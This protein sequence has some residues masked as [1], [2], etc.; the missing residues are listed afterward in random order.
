M[1]LCLLIQLEHGDGDMDSQDC[2]S[3]HDDHSISGRDDNLDLDGGAS[4]PTNESD[5]SDGNDSD[6][7]D[8]FGM[9]IYT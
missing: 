8:A 7:D 3:E 4:N 9:M 1:F 2:W 5:N 6:S